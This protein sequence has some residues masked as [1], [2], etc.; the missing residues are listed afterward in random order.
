MTAWAVGQTPRFKV[1]IIG[2][3]VSDW[4]MMAATSDLPS[5]E[6]VL[7]GGSPWDGIG[8]HRADALS[9]ISFARNVVT[10]LLILHGAEDARVPVSQGRLMAQALRATGTPYELVVYPREPHSIGERA[11]QLDMLRR[12]RAWVER[13]LDGGG[14][15]GIGG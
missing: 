4:G 5:F 2:A 14:E 9:P 11:H 12:V 1:G 7:G 6:A 8:P 13:W 10:P 15:G 3:G